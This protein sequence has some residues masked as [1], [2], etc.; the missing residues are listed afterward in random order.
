MTLSI[1]NAVDWTS[2]TKGLNEYIKESDGMVNLFFFCKFNVR[3]L[4]V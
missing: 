2:G 3:M 4:I 1:K